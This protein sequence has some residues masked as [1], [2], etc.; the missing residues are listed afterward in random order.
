LIRRVEWTVIVFILA[1]YLVIAGEYAT[2]TPDWQ[3]PDEPAHYN[4]VRQLADEGHFPVL[5]MGDWQQDYQTQLV[6]SGFDPKLTDRIQTIEY[7]DHQ[8]PLYYLL[9]TPIYALSDGNLITMRLFSMLL[10]A[11]VV[12]FTWLALWVLAPRWPGSALTGAAFVAFL[13]Q[14]ISILASV[15]NDALAELIVAVTL[16]ATLVYLGNRRTLPE[17]TDDVEQAVQPR[18]IHPVW[19]GVLVGLA[20]LTKTTI[21]FLAGV[22]ALA[23]VLRWRREHWPWQRAFREFAVVFIP[24]LLIGG[25]WWV[26]NLD[27]YGGTDFTGLT[28]HENVTIGQPRTDEWIDTVYGGST[29]MYLE[30][31]AKT[32]FRSFWGQFGW[33]ALPMPSHVYTALLLFSLAVISGAALFFWKHGWSRQLT[34]P[35]HDALLIFAAV[36]IFVSAAY[37]LYNLDF[38]QFQG[39]YLYPALLPFAFLVAAGLNGWT[40]LAENQFPALAWLPVTAM[41]GLAVFALYA[42]ETYIV[43]NLPTW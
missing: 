35:Q 36:F 38:V 3:A 34:P 24:A 20:L 42:L 9:Q 17:E 33:M 32:T 43:P 30:N 23:I 31:Y 12:G 16:L 6:A 25:V 29:R 22:V 41:I 27:V 26:R 10:G 1:A 4:Y 37:L 14:H 21:Y 13:P 7:E 18:K 39:R 40:S 19:L 15:S 2:R 5:E 28:R 8:P 11:G